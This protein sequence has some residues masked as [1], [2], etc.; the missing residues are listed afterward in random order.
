ML[1]WA[2]TQDEAGVGISVE[3][4]EGGG[5]FELRVT[6]V[7]TIEHLAP[8]AITCDSDQCHTSVDKT[9]AIDCQWDDDCTYRYD[10]Q[11][12]MGSGSRF[13]LRLH[14]VAGLT[15]RFTTELLSPWTGVHMN[16]GIY[17]ESALGGSESSEAIES[18]DFAL[19]Q[20]TDRGSHTYAELFEC[21]ASAEDGFH[22]PCAGER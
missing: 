15:Y 13:Q 10:A 14:G 8:E 17:H 7:G 19:G 20:W 11:E 12:L 1:Q 21:E 16:V 9:V 5:D 18:A 4:L 6:I 2:A 3:A 22:V